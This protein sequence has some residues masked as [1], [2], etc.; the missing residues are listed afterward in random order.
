MIGPM[1]MLSF[2]SINTGVDLCSGFRKK[3]ILVL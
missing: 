2:A 1:L 3:V